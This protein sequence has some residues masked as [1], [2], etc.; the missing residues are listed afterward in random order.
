MEDYKQTELDTDQELRISKE[1]LQSAAEH[2]QESMRS[3]IRARSAEEAYGNIVGGLLGIKALEKD[4]KKVLDSMP[5]N[6]ADSKTT[7]ANVN[8]VK[9]IA[10][11]VAS[12]AMGWA[13]TAN[14]CI[15]DLTF[16]RDH[17]E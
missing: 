12:V 9:E 6:F 3:Q 15:K 16:Q 11:A 4:A 5:G 14:L 10:Q 17:D 13:V 1:H 2:L 8:R 7:I